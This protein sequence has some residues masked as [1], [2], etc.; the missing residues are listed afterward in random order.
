MDLNQRCLK[1]T[2]QGEI[3][4]LV[5]LERDEGARVWLRFEVRDT[6][7]GIAPQQMQRLFQSFEQADTST[8]RR[9]GGTGL[10]LAISKSLAELMGGE[11]GVRSEPGQGSAFWIIVPLVRGEPL[12]RALLRSDWRGCRVRVRPRKAVRPSASGAKPVPPL[13]QVA[14][15]IRRRN[16]SPPCRQGE[17]CAGRVHQAPAVRVASS[18]ARSAAPCRASLPPVGVARAHSAALPD[19]A[20]PVGQNRQRPAK[21][22]P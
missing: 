21:V 11:V 7:I 14:R 20:D 5:R 3:H 13:L 10:G 4:L 6:G 15:S 18:A 17:C 22:L 9:Y 12:P 1:F 19:R 16:Q 8:T 2:E